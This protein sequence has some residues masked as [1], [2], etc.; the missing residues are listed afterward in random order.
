MPAVGP[1]MFL[2]SGDGV[3]F[4]GV[5]GNWYESESKEYH[6]SEDKAAELM[7]LVLEN[8]KAAHHEAPTE[9]FIH[10]QTCRISSDWT[11]LI[12]PEWDHPISGYW[13]HPISTIGT[14]PGRSRF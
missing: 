9:L 11:R 8:Y 12:S 14:T 4:R 1:Q 10:G 6:L 3:V 5:E 7:G 2:N 13:T